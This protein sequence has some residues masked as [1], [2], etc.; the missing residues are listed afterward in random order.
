MAILGAA[1]LC[2]LCM[3]GLADVA[4]DYDFAN[5]EDLLFTW[6]GSTSQATCL[7]GHLIKISVTK[8]DTSV[9]LSVTAF[10]PRNNPENP[11]SS[12]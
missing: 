12:P 10:R 11:K 9:E 7:T 2:P 5:E 8:T 4:P 1:I 6:R 3:S